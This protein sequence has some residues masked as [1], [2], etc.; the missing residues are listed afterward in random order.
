MR[1]AIAAVVWPPDNNKFVVYPEKKGNGVKPIKNGF[2]AKLIDF[3]WKPEQNFPRG[4]ATE[5]A[6]TEPGKF[7]AMLDLK[8]EGLSPFVVE[9]ETGNISSSHRALNKMALALRLG[10]ISGG[11]LVLP[12]HELY[13]YLTDRIGNYREIAPYLSLYT[14]IV[15]VE[16]GYLGIMVIEHDAIS[17]EVPKIQK[18]TDGRA[19]I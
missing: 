15:G 19:L 8:D 9:W 13:Q 4:E 11:V 16:H 10:R 12:T 6:V 5:I 17:A 7:D 3:G 2:V 14:D 1:Q 18:G